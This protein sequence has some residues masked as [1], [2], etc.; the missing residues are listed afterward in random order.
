MREERDKEE[1]F[2]KKLRLFSKFGLFYNLGSGR[3]GGFLKKICG[4]FDSLDKMY[5]IMKISNKI[6]I[7]G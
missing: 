3:G 2:S 5:M 7:G 4:P 1:Q 6:Q